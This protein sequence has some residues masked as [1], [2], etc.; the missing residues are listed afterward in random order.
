MTTKAPPKPSTL[1]NFVTAGLGG[2][3]GWFIIHPF[4]TVAI[5]MN[6]ANM[7]SGSNAKLS[8]VS[9]TSNMVQKEGWGSL[10]KGLSAGITR[11]IFYATS[12]FG[13][14]EVMRDFVAKY[15]QTDIWTRLFVGLVSGGAAA[16]ISCPAEVTLVRMSNDA[17]LPVDKRRNYTSLANAATRIA[18]EEGI[19]AFWR[20]SMPFVNRAMLVGACQIGTYDQFKTTF[21]SYGLTGISNEFCAAM[22]SGFIYSMIT[23]PFETAKNHMAFQKPD[24]VTGILPYRG[25]FQT[26]G[27][28]SAQKGVLSLWNGYLPYYGRCGGHTV[29]MFIAVEQ[30]RRAYNKLQNK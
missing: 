10:Y 20:G 11:Q 30:L 9:Y 25:T 28:V 21:A 26:I 4:N 29:F 13:L 2:V 8:M 1:V 7:T 3:I 6:L 23:M 17:S 15:R 19:V 5:R 18:S 24:P 27:A 16:L 22:A 12:R 14:F